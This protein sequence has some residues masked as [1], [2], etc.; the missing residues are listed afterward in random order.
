MK[1]I[2]LIDCNNFYVSCERLFQP[3]LRDQPVVVLSNNDGCVISRSNE[4]KQAGI[5]MGEPL[6]L[7]QARINRYKVRVF[8]SNFSLYGDISN[9][10]MTILKTF[11]KKIEIYS[12]DEAFLDLSH[13]P[14]PKCT[15]Y[16]ENM[17]DKI[18]QLVGIPVSIGLGPN[19]TLAKVAAS[20]AK[21]KAGVLNYNALSQIQQDELLRKLLVA[22]VWGIGKR[23]ASKLKALG[24]YTAYELRQAPTNLISN[25]L[26]VVGSR[27]QYE[28]QGYT[29]LEIETHTQNKKQ[30]ISSRSFGSTTNQLSD[31]EA[32]VS[33]FVSRACQKLRQQNSL[34][35]SLS[36]YIRSNPFSKNEPLTSLS[37]L[38][39]LPQ[40]SNSTP[41][42]IKT[43]KR[44]LQ[45][46]FQQGV[47]YKKAG[48]A[49]GMIQDTS[50][51][52]GIF[53]TDPKNSKLDGIID[54]L[55]R[56]C[57][58]PLLFY[59]AHQPTKKQTWQMQ[60]SLMSQQYTSSW[61]EL[62]LVKI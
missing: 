37:D 40:A 9:R 11:T 28:L 59:A 23:S 17:R 58:N 30:I 24:I 45:K 62:L 3:V 20:Y 54:Q 60:R 13:I 8:S 41:V 52:T 34:A 33:L 39:I 43:A 48:I 55:N 21:Q 4:A 5:A 14:A 29:C 15:E 47:F 10:I 32:A 46:I 18:Y 1:Q 61:K 25:K 50:Q 27:L 12:I 36:V 31:L 35:R 49:L 6:H 38:A 22:D 7:C 16:L 26:T 57:Q 51:Q 19:K 2:A 44:L 53:M 56:S 42:F